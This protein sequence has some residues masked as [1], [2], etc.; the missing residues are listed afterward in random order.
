MRVVD[1]YKPVWLTRGA[2]VVAIAL[3][4]MVLLALPAVADTSDETRSTVPFGPDLA[5][6]A[7]DITLSK[8]VVLSGVEF[9]V[10]IKV[11]NL[12]DE[13][14]FDVTVDLL[15]DTETVESKEVGAVVVDGWSIVTYTLTLT[16][17]DHDV[18]VLV[19]ADDAI[20]ERRE[21]NNDASISVRVRGL[22]D[23]SITDGDLS[24]SNAHPEEGQVVTISAM[25]HNLGESAATLVV[26]QFWDGVPGEGELIVNRTTSIPEAGQG[27]VTTQWDTTGRGGTHEINVVLSRVLPGED[28]LDNNAASI[29][30]LVFTMWDLVI[31]SITGDITIDQ[32][33]LQDGF[34][35][36]REGAT[37]TIVDIVFN[38]LQDYPHQ[39]ALFV[40]DGGSLVLQGAEVRSSQPLLIILE[41]GT[42]LVMSDHADVSA[43]IMMDGDVSI[44]MDSS[45]LVGGVQGN[46]SMIT[47]IDSEVSGPFEMGSGDIY[48][49]GTTLTSTSPCLLAGISAEFVDSILLGANA[50]SIMLREGST[51]ELRNVT[52]GDV[53]ADGTSTAFVFRR[54]DVHVV[55]EATLVIP[56]ASIEVRDFI[57]GTVVGTATGGADGRAEVEVLSDVIR[58]SETHFIGNYVVWS[59][60]SGEEGT[61]PLLLTPFPAMDAGANL[62]MVTV[63]LP[64]VEPR[65][66]VTSTAGDMVIES[67]EGKDLVADFIQ[68]GSII[69]R[70]TLTVTGATLSILQDRDHQFYVMVEG[71]GKLVLATGQLA[72]LKP[73]NVYLYDNASL[74]LGT[75]SSLSIK[76]LVAKDGATVTAS[77]SS[78][79]ARLL[80]RGG[81]VLL[82]NGCD[83][84]ADKIVID[85]PNVRIEGGTWTSDQL[86]I[87]SPATSIEG[88][89]LTSREVYL[90]GSFANISDSSIATDTFMA[91]TTILTVTG[92]Q[93]RAE[94]P[95]NL[96]V[97][98]FYMDTSTSNMPL[99]GGSP[100]SR[101]YLTDAQVPW[102]FTLGESTV[103]VYW[104]LTISVQDILGNPVSG[105]QVDVSYTNNGTAVTAGVTDGGGEVKFPLLGSIVDPV[106]GERF[107][108]NYRIEAQ[109]PNGIGEPVVRYVNMDQAKT[110]VSSFDE[111]IVQPIEV[112]VEIEVMNT[113]VEA[114]TEFI[115]TGVAIAKFEP[116]VKSP[117]SEGMV[118]IQLSNNESTWSNTTTL[119]ETGTFRFDVP[120]PMNDGIF[121][122]KAVVTPTGYYEGVDIGVS[123]I[124]TIDV[125]PPSAESLFIIIS[126]SIAT[127]KNDQYE[128]LDFPTGGYLLISGT[129]RYNTALGNPASNVIVLVKDP[130]TG[131][132]FQTPA[133]GLGV[134]QFDP[135]LGPRFKGQYDYFLTAKDD[136][137]G[138]E[139]LGP[140][141]LTIVAVDVKEEEEAKSNMLLYIIISIIIAVAA[142]GGTLGYWAFSTK[143]RMVECGECGTLVP[144]SAN[145]CPK[146]GIEFEVEVA[147][148]SECESWIRSD[149]ENC[150]YCGTAFKVIEEDGEVEESPEPAPEA[151]ETIT[152]EV[153]EE[154]E[155]DTVPEE[156]VVVDEEDMKA[157]PETV[158]QV[159]E[160]IK[161]EVRP[162]P[163]VTKKA[164]VDVPGEDENGASNGNVIARPRVKRLAV[165][166]QDKPVEPE[167][168]DESWME[169]TEES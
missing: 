12:G 158:K 164:V 18:G 53:D 51:V 149:A 59:S 28:V 143:G 103:L 153:D 37:L 84:E 16:Q 119:D 102:P 54:V 127:L 88:L 82:E 122:L 55:D 50:P 64:P 139:T 160:G 151:P 40:E 108:G 2:C 85:A 132:T 140:T 101:V 46:A 38:F 129:V 21:D 52:C 106:E 81:Q 134:F 123:N 65:D 111:P 57:N 58:N 7:G 98:T 71:N 113:S 29:T 42:N 117:L 155:L 116:P 161:K 168:D 91:D 69:V 150:P 133:D 128:I 142:I 27:L 145:N 87:S 80:L 68:D 94:A 77:G 26:V 146:C 96:S 118:E 75:G 35:T 74:E 109:N 100:D 93:I 89:D 62:P 14:A 11:Y 1:L 6:S 126:P 86:L 25:V 156:G 121:Y 92:T 45:V 70:G 10:S 5:V 4:A 165:E 169:E 32:D 8:P 19:D 31:D 138:I 34:V 97:S 105:S 104:Y 107:V 130:L 47:I 114:G 163:V 76:T 112:T 72:S 167:L 141:K 49:E 60:F 154:V 63:T 159:P 56:G 147:K 30:V 20:D 90:E 23:A 22:P 166:P 157:S 61:E 41:D 66:L 110:V 115:V 152:V 125:R 43:N 99:D 9:N 67:G 39:F 136:D 95:L 162:R 120:A 148:C 33:R 83:L 17:G 73:I 144:D 3:A 48:V 78:L 135:I 36:V 13:D 124:I 15:V 24:V 44:S 137:L 79:E 131:T